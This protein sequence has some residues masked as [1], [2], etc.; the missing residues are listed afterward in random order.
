[1]KYC[2]IIF[3][4]ISIIPAQHIYIIKHRI[5]AVVGPV[6]RDGHDFDF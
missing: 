4:L 1:M 2:V 5:L 6:C 3:L